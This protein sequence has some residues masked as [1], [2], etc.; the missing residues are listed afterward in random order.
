MNASLPSITST[1]QFDQ[2]LE[3]K[4]AD[5]DIVVFKVSPICNMSFTAE[6]QV[7]QWLAEAGEDPGVDWFTVDVIGDRPVSKYLE[8]HF[9]ILHESPQILWI[10]NDRTVRWHGSHR[11]ISVDNLTEVKNGGSPARR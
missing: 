6:G 9:G 11:A 2:L 3:N 1:E 7:D 4:T 10:G 5:R 8:K